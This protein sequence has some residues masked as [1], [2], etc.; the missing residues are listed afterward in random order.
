MAGHCLA[1]AQ[2]LLRIYEAVAHKL[3][4]PVCLFHG[5]CLATG[6]Y[7]RV[8]IY[9]YFKNCNFSIYF[10][11]KPRNFSTGYTYIYRVFLTKNINYFTK[12]YKQISLFNGAAV[13]FLCGING[14]FKYYAD[15]LLL[16]KAKKSS[17]LP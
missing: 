8:Y 16:Q 6:L 2:V 15:Q 9:F 4:L 17:Y 12:N 7:T 13:C 3:S 10:Y 11:I 5:R 1:T 14:I